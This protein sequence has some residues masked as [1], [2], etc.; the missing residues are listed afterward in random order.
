MLLERVAGI[1]VERGCGRM[2]WTVLDWN[3]SAIGFYER[4]GARAM[5]EWRL[6]RLTGEP[7]LRLAETIRRSGP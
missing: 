5:S 7:L 2:E 1:A 6:F 3:E 4:L